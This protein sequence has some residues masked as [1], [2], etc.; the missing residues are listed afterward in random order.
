MTGEI[1]WFASE[2]GQLLVA[3][4]MQQAMPWVMPLCGHNA[5][6]LQPS[7]QIIVQPALQCAPVLSISRHNELF[8]GD[9]IAHDKNLPLA[10]D[11]MALVYAAFV[12]ETSVTPALLLA[13]FERLLLSEGHLALLTLNPYCPFRMSGRWKKFVLKSKAY[14]AQYLQHAG[15]ELVQHQALG[16]LWPSAAKQPPSVFSCRPKPLRSVNFILAK[17]RKVAVTPIRKT[18]HAIALARE[19]L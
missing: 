10:S 16:S 19:T 5:L 2:A 17:K 11:C 18:S 7:K 6:V 4:S 8:S 3:Q 13:E 14:W 1:N 12:L 15:L 9:F